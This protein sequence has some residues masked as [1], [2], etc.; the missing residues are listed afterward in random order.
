LA[1][2][3]IHPGGFSSIQDSGRP[4]ARAQGVPVGGAADQYAHRLANMVLQNA[5]D[6]ATVEICGGGWKAQV[7][8]PLEIVL[9]APPTAIFKIN[10]VPAALGA[11]HRVEAG[12]VLAVEG[13]A[14]YQYLAVRG[15]WQAK[16]VLGSAGFCKAGQF[17]GGFDR[18][19]RAGDQI[20]AGFFTNGVS[21][22]SWRL[23]PTLLH[24]FYASK[25]PAVIRILPGPEW[26]WWS[27]EQ[28]EWFLSALFSISTRRDRMGVR[29]DGASGQLALPEAGGMLSS[30]TVPGAIQ[31]PPDGSPF[32]LLCDAQTTGGYPRI[33]QVIAADVPVL[34][35]LATGMVLGFEK[36][37]IACAQ[38]LLEAQERQLRQLH[39]AIRMRANTA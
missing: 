10:G 2:Q 29:L 8:S 12:N 22:H 3:I 30:G 14:N 13:S 32:V 7:I 1:I 6:C 18:P 16:K 38:H 31:V 25:T 33:A 26:H 37:D 35:Q 24:G 28:Q 34:T 5:A 17:G 4:R 39:H 20:Q 21:R 9:T 15:G 27:Q 23:S 36:T 19:L 11:I